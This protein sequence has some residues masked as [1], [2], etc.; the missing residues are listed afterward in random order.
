MNSSCRVEQIERRGDKRL[1]HLSNGVSLLTPGREHCDERTIDGII[2]EVCIRDDYLGHPFLSL[3]NPEPGE[4]II[5]IGG[6]IGSFAT[7]AANRYP[8]VH[9]H[10]FEP[11]AANYA[12]LIEN[13]RLN[14]LAGRVSASNVAVASGPGNRTIY[15]SP[16]NSGMNSF[17]PLAGDGNVKL[18]VPTIRLSDYLAQKGVSGI[19]A[20]KLDC[21]GAEYE[22]LY[23]C[24]PAILQRTKLILLEYH[25]ITNDVGS[26]AAALCV[27]LAGQ[28]FILEQSI[29]PVGSMIYAIHESCVAPAAVDV[30]KNYAAWIKRS[31]VEF[32]AAMNIQREAFAHLTEDR[33]AAQQIM[34]H[35]AGV[36]EELRG[37]GTARRSAQPA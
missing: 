2:H 13:L 37:N 6:H 30:V 19:F 23:N 25:E 31:N 36:I 8:G 1:F 3:V 10:S 11:L 16:A 24:D 28:G 12:I 22:I 33:A 4:V 18:T 15:A 32:A 34:E 7:L 21:E 20:L 35:Q 9:I 5:D 29:A 14:G 27:F 17:F 26:N